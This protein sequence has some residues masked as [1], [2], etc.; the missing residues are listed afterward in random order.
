M[1]AKDFTLPAA[2]ELPAS[3]KAAMP[4]LTVMLVNAALAFLAGT[5]ILIIGWTLSRWVG[6]WLRDAMR[7]LPMIDPTLKP[8][9][10]SLVRY[11]ILAVTLVAVMGQ[12]GIQTTSFIALVGAAG[13]AVGLALQGTLSNVASGVMLLGLRPFRAYDKVKVM[14]IVGT[15]DEIGLFRTILLT[16][17]GVYISIPNASIFSA[18]ISNYSRQ[19]TR[20][21]DFTVDIDH[22][23]DIGAAQAAILAMLKADS[24]VLAEPEPVVEVEALN[25][26]ST[27]LSV[28][29]WVTNKDFGGVRS[30]L[31][32]QVRG[33]L[34]KA[35]IRPPVPLIAAP[36][37]ARTQGKIPAADSAPG[38]G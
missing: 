16:D 35:G 6:R 24:R 36:P 22:G 29:A 12:F 21:A 9:I 19:R 25:G 32:R 10:A 8:L 31:R 13:L 2:A 3:I 34:E 37:P 5:L 7:N 20:R 15:V 26:I 30:D 18:T 38:R 23:D 17:D 14:D 27:L 33:T 28:Q 4:A 11:A 1:Q